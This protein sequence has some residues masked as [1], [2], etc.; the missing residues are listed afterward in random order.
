[1]HLPCVCSLSSPP[2][3]P[4][5]PSPFA[6]SAPSAA[7]NLSVVSSLSLF[8]CRVCLPAPHSWAAVRPSVAAAAVLVCL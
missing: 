7:A 1:M 6:L 4:R 8:A 2:A 5:R 3:T